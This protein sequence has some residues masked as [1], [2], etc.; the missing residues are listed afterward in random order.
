LKKLWDILILTLAMN[1]AAVL[2]FVL[3]L[4]QD[5]RLGG[6]R[7]VQIRHVL[8]PEHAPSEPVPD[9]V[10]AEA[11]PTS[12][13]DNLLVRHAGAPAAE[14]VRLIQQSF[15]AQT[16]LLDRRHRDLQNLQH[17]VEQAQ[18]RLAADRARVEAERA[19][20]HRQRQELT[21]QS[22]DRGFQDSLDRY[23][24][25]PTRQAKDI[26]M[27]LDERTLMSYLQAMPPR[28]AARFIREFRTPQELE[29][30]QAVMEMMRIA[31]IQ[32]IEGQ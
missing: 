22:R 18:Q 16:I 10:I 4:Y 23:V 11:P 5:G 2:V 17:Q 28:T 26:F 12:E 20:L 19:A 6:E 30:I 8:W 32:E 3:W 25:M 27:T 21:E 31:S 1:F 15:E 7:I 13:L 29:R 24:A 14:Q 9:N